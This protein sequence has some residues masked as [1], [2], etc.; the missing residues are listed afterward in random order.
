[1]VNGSCTEFAE[2]LLSAESFEVMDEIRPKV[3]DVVTRKPVSLLDDDSFTTQ[4]CHL[5]SQS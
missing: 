3:K 1:M 5:D 2:K 4:Q